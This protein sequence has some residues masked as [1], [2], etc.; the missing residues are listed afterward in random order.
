MLL[1][2]LASPAFLSP[3]V[4]TAQNP[5]F[6]ATQTHALAIARFAEELLAAFD[7]LELGTD[8]DPRGDGLKSVREGLVGLI[9]KITSPLIGGIR[10]E[11][12]AL[13]EALEV[14]AKPAAGPKPA[15]AYHPSIIALQTTMPFYA[16]ALAR[17]ASST[18]A[19]ATTL[20]SLHLTVLWKGMVALAH[21][22]EIGPSAPSSPVAVAHNGKK[23]RGSPP[24]STPPTTP[25]A[26]K[27]M[28]KLP[29]SRPPSPT[30]GTHAVSAVADCRALYSLLNMLPRP[31]DDKATTKV[32]REAVDEAF[33]GLA[34]LA[35]FLE[36]IQAKTDG[37]SAET[38][39]AELQ[40]LT[41]E[42]PTLIALPPMLRVFC[43]RD[44]TV[45]GMLGIAE[46]EYRAGPLAGFG[47]AER[48][49]GAVG[50]LVLEFLERS[51][52]VN[53]IAI[54]WLGAE[55]DRD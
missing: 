24:S 35:A 50:R 3:F 37:K 39:V 29:A 19:Q 36:A 4:P 43:P 10:N 34:A 8:N 9:Q 30:A 18:Y 55:L 21:R 49:A 27:F 13:V 44:A 54:K 14:A 16:R 25:P 53:E 51:P 20:A 28:L 5:N 7:Q 26:S 52:E 17:C 40:T 23:R 22:Q 42:I 12:V 45:A 15:S 6:N 2:L 41:D 47:S 32:A 31:S 33:E 38:V 11:L 1:Q 46:A 48:A